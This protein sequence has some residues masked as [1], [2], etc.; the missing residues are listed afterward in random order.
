MK[1]LLALLLAA[2]MVFSMVA[3]GGAEKG[4]DKFEIVVVPKDSSNPWFVRMDTGVKEYAAAHTEL[5]VY[6]KGTDQI[7]AALLKSGTIKS[8]TLWDPA[9]AGQAMI[10]LAVKVL[11]GEPST[12]LSTWV[13]KATI[14][15]NSALVAPPFWKARAGLPSTLRMLIASASNFCFYNSQFF[16]LTPYCV[17]S[18]HINTSISNNSIKIMVGTF[19]STIILSLHQWG[20]AFWFAQTGERDTIGLPVVKS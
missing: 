4:D 19:M 5:N 13:L 14:L 9:V 3:C 15:W 6:Q 20:W 16:F 10:S 1:K 8:L 11:N 17:F 12:V 7:D 18:R 2:L